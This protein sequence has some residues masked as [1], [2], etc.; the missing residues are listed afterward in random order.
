[1]MSRPDRPLRPTLRRSARGPLAALAIG[2]SL[3]PGF[4]C[5]REYFRHWADQD[6][7]EAV[8]EKSR[9]PRWA[10]DAF[11][12][13]PPALSRYADPYDIDRPPAPPDDVATEAL[14]TTAQ[15][16]FHRLLV[17]NEG[18]GY[19]DLMKKGPRYIAP[20]PVKPVK[21]PVP[22][23][24]PESEAPAPFNPGPNSGTNP[25][26]STPNNG[27]PAP[28]GGP[29]RPPGSPEAIP[30]QARTRSKDAG[31]LLTTFQAPG[32]PPVGAAPA[33]DP[34]QAV[35]SSR[36]TEEKDDPRGLGNTGPKTPVVGDIPPS[37]T[38]VVEPGVPRT[39]LSPEERQKAKAGSASFSPLK[40][41]G[42]LQIDEAQIA[43]FAS[44]SRP[45]IV[46]PAMALQLA[47]Q[48]N[49]G[50]QFNLEQIYLQALAVTA[51]RFSF[52]PQFYAGNN[53]VT[54]PAGPNTSVGIQQ[55]FQNFFTYRTKEAL[56]GQNS[57]LSY[58]TAAGVGKALSFGGAFVAGFANNTVFNFLSSKPTQPSIASYL[59]IA[60]S[61]PFLRG[62]GR[63]VTL[64]TLTQSERN[65]VYAIR[66]FAKFRQDMIP[67]ILTFNTP[68]DPGFAGSPLPAAANP[69]GD[70]T[71]GYL[72]VLVNIQTVENS[73][74]TVEAYDRLLRLYK[75]YVRGSASS[76]ISQIQVDQ[77]ASQ[78]QQQRGTLINNEAILRNNLD[79]FRVGLGLPTDTPFILDREMTSGFRNVFI[80]LEKWAERDDHEQDE[81]FSIIGSLPKLESVVLDDR[82]LFR[83]DKDGALAQ[84]YANPEKLQEFLLAAERIALENRLDLM[85][86]RAQLYDSWRQIA[87]TSNGLLG[88]FNV[89][90]T[91]NIT[92][93]PTSS[94]P[95]GFSDQAKQFSLVLQ[96]EL[97]LIRV[98]QRNLYRQS[99]IT[100]RRQQR[101]LM[102]IEDDLKQ[103]VRQ[104][105]Y[106]IINFGENY[107][108]A[109]TTLLLNI[110]QRDNIQQ[111]IIAPPTSIDAGTNSASQASATINLLNA[112]NN[113]LGVENQLIQNWVQFQTERLQL[114]RDTGLMPIDEWEAFYELFP[115]NSAPGGNT[116]S[117]R[118]DGPAASGAANPS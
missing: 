77:V 65:L 31:V 64:E 10:L 16:P 55:N 36:P 40:G 98:T 117:G 11:T 21:A 86:A 104:D 1:M 112:I 15:Y 79:Q 53:P 50:Y 30:P 32:T 17:P 46:N 57:A 35:P 70:P 105:V 87:V 72:Q 52:Q 38:N 111:L 59:P 39:D 113:V 3:A 99:L 2:L 68:F 14:T 75:E 13:E 100:F 48:N 80:N 9:D 106:A 58:G 25:A 27:T 89:T 96:T 33:T 114:Y 19:L 44:E 83:Y 5:G 81:L 4:G 54:A 22:P 74:R 76:G 103:Q 51:A 23:V 26:G 41:A 69:T 49:R 116:P 42:S 82:K 88:V 28:P 78:L 43:G 66:Q 107:E 92:T 97:P 101:N 95:F 60:Y 12:T 115:S 20:P 71:P 34:T 45:F 102:S 108:I 61:Q 109:K 24:I 73:R 90:V 6:V 84:V 91:N 29:D 37:T 118:A 67:T 7:A 47:L 8:F 93:P 62:G 63:A 56:G 85:N 18:T 94:N 110:R